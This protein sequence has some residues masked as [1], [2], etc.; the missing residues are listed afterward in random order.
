MYEQALQVFA[1]IL[2]MT[3]N[4]LTQ[5]L[6]FRIKVN[7]SLLRSIYLGFFC[8]LL[9]MIVFDLAIM[10]HNESSLNYFIGIFLVNLIIYGSLGY[11]Y[12]NFNNLGET[13]R[14]IRLL[15]EIYDSKEGLTSV[16]LVDLYSG[17]EVLSR[18][19]ERLLKNN[20][21]IL[22]DNKY[23]IGN[24]SILWIANIIIFLKVMVLGKK[25]E[26]D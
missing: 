17:K 24:P 4:V 9:T 25:T 13:A 20:Q 22:R 26:F 7:L 14:R 12:F 11:C 8:G 15:R 3:V 16:E 10:I 6:S 2:G 1:P 23:L 19:I 21:V 5:I 18:R